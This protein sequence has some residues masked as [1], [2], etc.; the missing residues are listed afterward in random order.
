MSRSLPH[1][2]EQAL[3][4]SDEFCARYSKPRRRHGRKAGGATVG[5]APAT[6]PRA[7][8]A[9]FYRP[10]DH[11]AS[12]LFQVVREHFDDFEKVYPERYQKAYGYWR[13]VIRSSIDKFVKCG[14]LKRGFARVRCP[15]CRKD[16]FVAFSCRSRFKSGLSL[17][18]PEALFDPWIASECA[19]FRGRTASTVGIY[20]PPAAAGV[21]PI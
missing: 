10:R 2:Q 9:T 20:H 7:K 18:R 1:L 12:A 17:L 4:R 5:A 8:P 13:P 19:G 16:F 14:D 21:L 3:Q 15:D 11:E 6:R